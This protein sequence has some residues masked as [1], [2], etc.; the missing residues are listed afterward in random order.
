[1][2]KIPH[3]YSATYISL[4]S[5]NSF[6]LLLFALYSLLPPRIFFF[7]FYSLAGQYLR[8]DFDLD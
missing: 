8:L 5:P 4:F 2:T 3:R 6:L 1:M 7:L